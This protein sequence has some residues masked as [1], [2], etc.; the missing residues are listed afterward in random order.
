MPAPAAVSDIASRVLV[1]FPGALGDLICFGPALDAIARANAGSAIELMAKPELVRFF[2]GRT[3]VARGHSIDRREVAALFAVD[4]ELSPSAREFFSEFSRLY[5]YLAFDDPKFR[6]ALERYAPGRTTFQPFRPGGSGHVSAGYLKMLGEASG[7]HAFR[8]EVGRDDIG[9]ALSALKAAGVEADAPFVAIFPGSGS[10]SKNWPIANYLELV[11]TLPSGVQPL[12][13]LGPAEDGLESAVTTNG[14]PVLKDLELAT[15]AGVARLAA[16]FVG[17]DS[18]VSHV[19]AAVGASGVSIFGPTNPGRWRPLGDV[20]II[21][22]PSIDR[23]SV[24]EV[25]EALKNLL[26]RPLPAQ[27]VS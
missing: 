24:A 18:G 4:S 19:A 25:A 12:V 23:I 1:I 6:A 9:M 11:A 26:R 5:S 21:A 13:V 2:V 3:C 17:N 8:I 27:D 10:P 16:A 22:H 14:I 20:T 15:V 7:R